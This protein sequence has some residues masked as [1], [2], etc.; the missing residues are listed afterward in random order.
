MNKKIFQSWFELPSQLFAHR[1]NKLTNTKVRDDGQRL[2]GGGVLARH[3]VA[4]V[5]HGGDPHQA[6]REHLQQLA[7]RYPRV[8][9]AVRQPCDGTR[10][11]FIMYSIFFLA[12]FRDKSKCNGSDGR[13]SDGN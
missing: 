1:P 6:Q 8:R 10:V 2:P 12:S 13:Q 4:E 5:E 7:H 11:S 3:E 9:R